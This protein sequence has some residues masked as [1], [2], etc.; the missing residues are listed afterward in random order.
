MAPM[1]STRPGKSIWRNLSFADVFL[2]GLFFW[3]SG[4]EKVKKMMI[5]AKPPIGRLM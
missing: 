1:M 4:V 5:A 3:A 2:S